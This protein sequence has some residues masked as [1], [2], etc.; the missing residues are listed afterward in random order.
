M[1]L[2]RRRIPEGLCTRPSLSP[3]SRW[4]GDPPGRDR[5]TRRPDEPC[6]PS[7]TASGDQRGTG[8]RSE[9][10]G[11]GN[12]RRPKHRRRCRSARPFRLRD[13]PRTPH[14]GL[15]CGRPWLGA[16]DG[17]HL[18]GPV[19]PY[20]RHWKGR[21]YCPRTRR[22]A[23]RSQPK[24]AFSW[25]A[26]DAHLGPHTIRGS[27]PFLEVWARCMCQVARQDDTNALAAR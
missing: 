27:R 19:W 6:T 21:R 10:A 22:S 7:R 3:S 26:T 2:F 17:P 4:L 5:R 14:P 15:S 1:T 25:L 20:L 9:P 18:L 23:P 11:N 24:R 8:D 12:R 16:G 13:P